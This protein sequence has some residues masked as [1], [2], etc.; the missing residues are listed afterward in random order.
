MKIKPLI[1]GLLIAFSSVNQCK[2]VSAELVIGF[3]VNNGGSFSN[4]FDVVT[5]QSLTV[6]LYLQQTNPDTVLTDEGIVA[7]GL[8]LT[9]APT[10]L[11]TISNR[12]VNPLFDFENHNVTTASGFEW[13]YGETANTG[14]KGTSVLL[15]SLQFDTTADGTTLFTVGDRLVGTGAV[16]ASWLTPSFSFLDEQIFGAGATNDF[17]FS[18]NASAV[19]EPSSFAMFSCIAGLAICRRR[20][21]VLTQANCL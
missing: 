15:G 9:S 4:S 1:F 17:R 13:E 7:W 5:G 19:P 14:I 12:M 20:R 16:N 8:G 3:S 2:L 11:G 10:N 21:S 18:I 6:G